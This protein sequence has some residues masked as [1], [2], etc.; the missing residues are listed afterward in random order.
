MGTFPNEPIQ[1]WTLPSLTGQNCIL[2]FLL[3][4]CQETKTLSNS[5]HGRRI[6]SSRSVTATYYLVP[7][8]T[9][10]NKQTKK[11]TTE[12]KFLCDFCRRSIMA[13]PREQHLREEALLMLAATA[14][15]GVQPQNTTITKRRRHSWNPGTLYN[16]ILMF[17][18]FSR[19]FIYKLTFNFLISLL[20]KNHSHRGEHLGGRGRRIALSSGQ[21]WS[22]K[23]LRQSQKEQKKK[24]KRMKNPGSLH[25]TC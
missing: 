14:E 19:D 6:R 5:S 9:K 17:S 12:H 2:H 20:L 23:L 1:N 18:L 10:Q 15:Q 21:F 13:D 16:L 11:A 8:H 4:L 22:T 3:C 7:K 24:K 25:W